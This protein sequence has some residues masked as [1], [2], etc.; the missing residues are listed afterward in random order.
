MNARTVNKL[1][2]RNRCVQPVKRAALT[3]RVPL[4]LLPPQGPT[5]PPDVVNGWFRSVGHLAWE[6]RMEGWPVLKHLFD[7]LSSS[8]GCSA[9]VCSGYLYITYNV[10]W[11]QRWSK[12][13]FC[14][15][16]AKA[17]VHASQCDRKV[18]VLK[19]PQFPRD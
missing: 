17:C 8:K 11:F 3:I 15:E 13:R 5:E 18:K 14:S 7:A 6:G 1:L 2:M 19:C 12:N 4:D 9:F 10:K 16:I